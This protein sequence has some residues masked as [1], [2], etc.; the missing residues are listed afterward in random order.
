MS[1]EPADQV[2]AQSKVVKKAAP[3]NSAELAKE[4]N[5]AAEY[6]WALSVFKSNPELESIFQHAVKI[7]QSA[8]GFA[9]AV[10]STKWFKQHA[11]SWRQATMLQLTDP[12]TF[13]NKMAENIA[14]V[15]KQAGQLGIRLTGKQIEN[16]ASMA[17]YG[18]WTPDVL[19]Q[20]LGGALTYSNF[21]QNGVGGVLESSRENLS[22]WAANNGVT[23]TQ[24]QM[25]GWLS[26]IASGAGSEQQY[27]AA[28]SK[29]AAAMFPNWANELNQGMSIKDVASPYI[30]SMSQLLEVDPNSIQATNPLIKGALTVKDP[31]SGEL[32]AMSLNSFEQSVRQDPR[33]Q[34]T[35]NARQTMNGVAA[36]IGKSWGIM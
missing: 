3:G 29:Q 15:Q 30:N 34:Y 2:A 6:G 28:I 7:S 23:L 8:A 10:Q 1:S 26:S 14:S 19:D 4:T 22:N 9:A 18:G 21:T 27:K 5:L 17:V 20:H 24:H 32:S 11:D 31:K 16:F 33:W 25:T 36:N 35:D 12:A 13:H